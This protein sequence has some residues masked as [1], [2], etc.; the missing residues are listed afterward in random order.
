MCMFVSQ[1]RAAASLA[2]GGKGR[3]RKW[4]DRYTGGLVVSI[5]WHVWK[6]PPQILSD[7]IYPFHR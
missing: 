4:A 5:G 6:A 1:N 7:E 2:H 3:R